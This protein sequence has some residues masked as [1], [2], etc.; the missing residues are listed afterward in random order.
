[1]LYGRDLSVCVFLENVFC[2]PWYDRILRRVVRRTPEWFKDLEFIENEH[3][4]SCVC[5]NRFRVL[6]R[7][8]SKVKELE[9]T[10]RK[11]VY[12]ESWKFRK[13][14]NTKQIVLWFRLFHQNLLVSFS[15]MMRSYPRRLVSTLNQPHK[16]NCHTYF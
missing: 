3:G 8:L 12:R 10:S 9:N 4:L 1:M 6:K 7:M 14:L 11:S 13:I 2:F 5:R 15:K 16:V